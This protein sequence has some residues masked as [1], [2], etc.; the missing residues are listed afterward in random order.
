MPNVDSFK[1]P[2]GENPIKIE[3]KNAEACPRYSALLLEGVSVGDSPD[4]LKKRLESIGVRSIN[5][6][7]DI[8]NFVLYEI[9]QPLH[10][11]DA[12]KIAGER[13]IVQTLPQGTKFV[14]LDAVERS[15][16]AEDLNDLRCGE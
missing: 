10:A 4:W 7:V 9:G 12:D 6:V 11:F 5:N 16:F 14:S 2:N 8:T 1:A 13:V 3:V 15:L